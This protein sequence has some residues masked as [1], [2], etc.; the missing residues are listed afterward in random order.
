MG[1]FQPK[2]HI[3]SLTTDPVVGYD[4][5]DHVSTRDY[6]IKIATASTAEGLFDLVR[7][8]DPDYGKR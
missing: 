5:S 2:L 7:G 3:A 4:E 6:K 1:R 8:T